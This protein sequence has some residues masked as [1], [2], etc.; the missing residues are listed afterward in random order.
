MTTEELYRRQAQKRTQCMGCA[1]KLILLRWEGKHREINLKSVWMIV[2]L[3]MLLKIHLGK[4]GVY[5]TLQMSGHTPS[6]WES[7]QELNTGTWS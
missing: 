5:S 4:E 1:M 3:A 2:S 7:R 6:L